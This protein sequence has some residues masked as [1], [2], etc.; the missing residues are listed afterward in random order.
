MRIRERLGVY[1]IERKS[2]VSGTA[3]KASI[4]EAGG[5]TSESE[6]YIKIN[7]GEGFS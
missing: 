5:G 3:Y 4:I 2:S 7:W 1:C 6:K